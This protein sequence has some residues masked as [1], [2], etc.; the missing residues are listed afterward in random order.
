MSFYCEHPT[1]IRDHNLRSN[2]LKYRN[3]TFRGVSHHLS[4]SEYVKWCYNFPHYMFSPKAQRIQADE[5]ESCYVSTPDGECIPMFIQVPCG[6]CVLCSEKHR[7]EWSLRVALESQCYKWRPLF[8]TLTYRPS[9]TPVDGV[10]KRDVQLFFKRLRKNYVTE[11]PEYQTNASNLRYFCVSEYGKN[12][13]PH[14]HIILWNM[15]YL[16]VDTDLYALI[17]KSWGLGRTETCRVKNSAGKYCCKY[18]RKDDIIPQGK[19]KTFML[20]SRGTRKNQL[21]GIGYPWLKKHMSFYLSHPEIDDILVFDFFSGREIKG[22]IPAY[23]KRKLYPTLSLFINPKMRESFK[24]LAHH[25]EHCVRLSS[26]SPVLCSQ[27]RAD[28][29]PELVKL[30]AKYPFFDLHYP[31]RRY[32]SKKFNDLL[33]LE[34]AFKE[35]RNA[36]TELTDFLLSCDF[37]YD[38]VLA[39]L[40]RKAIHSYKVMMKHKDDV[41]YDISFEVSKILKKRAEYKTQEKL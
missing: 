6:K 30:V 27:F 1:I 5:L 11:Y 16:P 22:G 15:P 2:I 37:N 40:E 17:D 10:N 18:M 13:L 7:N 35:S 9:E 4:Y 14:Y 20:S 36:I 26:S 19:N 23:F 38:D 41:P 24:L 29:C 28:N 3:Y 12:G 39:H 32:E 31:L 33:N 8:I 25:V 21:G 34:Q